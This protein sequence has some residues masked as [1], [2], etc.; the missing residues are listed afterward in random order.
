MKPRTRLF[1]KY[2][3]RFMALVGGVLLLSGS[4][5][6][7]FSFRENKAALVALQREKADAAAS[8]IEQFIRII[9][10]QIGWANRSMAAGVQPL[11]R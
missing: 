4:L 6:L 7:Y 9:E 10:D 1:R 5:D 11:F 3:V 2:A 8:R